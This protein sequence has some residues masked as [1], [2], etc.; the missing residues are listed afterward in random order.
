ML[1]YVAGFGELARVPNV[2]EMMRGSVEGTTTAMPGRQAA[3][4]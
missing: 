1:T 4:S 2:P 3:R